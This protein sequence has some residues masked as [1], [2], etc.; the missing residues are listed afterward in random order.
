MY[1]DNRYAFMGGK[2]QREINAQKRNTFI[3][4]AVISFGI[5]KAS[6]YFA[7]QGIADGNIYTANHLSYVTT[8]YSFAIGA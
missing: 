6:E 7:K 4:Q 8:T 2:S 3:I 1:S 5:I